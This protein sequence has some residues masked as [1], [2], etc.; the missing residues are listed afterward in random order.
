MHGRN[1]GTW[2]LDADLALIPE[3]FDALSEELEAGDLDRQADAVSA[4]TVGQQ[5]IHTALVATSLALA[6]RRILGGGGSRDGSI[7]EP[8]TGILTS[9]E[10]PRGVGDAPEPSRRAETPAADE[11]AGA[12]EKARAK[13]SAISPRTDDMRAAADRLPHPALGPMTAVEWV[14]FQAVHAAHHLKIVD[15]IRAA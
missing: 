6:I 8:G 10:I 14:R 9:G 3:Q 13:W 7:T 4:W 1:P 15:D 2:D 11:I 12:I 5:L